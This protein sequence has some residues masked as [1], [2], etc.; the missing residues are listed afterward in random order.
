MHILLECIKN[1]TESELVSRYSQVKEFLAN[2]V[3][4]F[5]QPIIG[6]DVIIK[7]RVGQKISTTMSQGSY[8]SDNTTANGNYGGA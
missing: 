1:S 6:I 3:K 7:K 4:G 8:Y 2:S 5:E